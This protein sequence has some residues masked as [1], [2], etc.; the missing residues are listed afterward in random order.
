MAEPVL[1]DDE[2]SIIADELGLLENLRSA[3]DANVFRQRGSQGETLVSLREE[4]R[5][6]SVDDL[7]ML[8][9]QLHELRSAASHRLGSPLPDPDVPYFAHM[10]IEMGGRIRDVLIAPI[11]PNRLTAGV[12]REQLHHP[13]R[14]AN[15]LEDDALG[16]ARRD[17][18]VSCPPVHNPTLSKAPPVAL[19][20]WVHVQG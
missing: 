8:H 9:T 4:M 11:D 3:V 13:V 12:L 2:R 6:A 17:K 10:R 20:H 7:P 5:T 19:L 15:G 16:R 1:S 18:R 14:V